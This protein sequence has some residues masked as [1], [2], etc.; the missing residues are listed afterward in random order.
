MFKIPISK[1]NLTQQDFREIKKCFDSTW[2]SSKSPWVERFEGE[3]ARKVAQ[4]KYAVSVNSGTSALFLALLALGV[5]EGDE[6]IIPTFTMIATINAI[7]LTGARP[8]L[9]DSTSKEDWSMDP[10]GIEKK[11][12]PKTKII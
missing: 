5:G 3:F 1:P 11:I 8:V 7:Y 12:T 10:K 4:T 6:V 2:I 9:V